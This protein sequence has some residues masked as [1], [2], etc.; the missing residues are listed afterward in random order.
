MDTITDLSPSQITQIHERW[1]AKRD[2]SP[3]ILSDLPGWLFKGQVLYFA[4]PS[5]SDSRPS[6]RLQRASTTARFAG[7]TVVQDLDDKTVTHV[8]VEYDVGTDI[9]ALRAQIAKRV[10]GGKK[11]PHMVSVRWIEES[12]AE[13]TLV[14]EERKF[15][16][17]FLL[18]L[19]RGLTDELML[20]FAAPSK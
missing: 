5:S 20:G 1:A 8:V 10:G 3:T 4:K 9:P 13:K 19:S 6:P 17:Y 15:F 16:G 14:D 18:I 12:W 7:A 2:G 11:V